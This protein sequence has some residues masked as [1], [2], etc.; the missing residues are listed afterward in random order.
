MIRSGAVI[1]GIVELANDLFGDEVTVI[2]GPS[3]SRPAASQKILCVGWDQNSPVHASTARDESTLD[4]RPTE[5][6]VVSC[7]IATMSGNADMKQSRD[8]AVDLLHRLEDALI[9]DRTGLN[10]ACDVAEIGPETGLWQH[11]T[12]QGASVGIPFAVMYEAYL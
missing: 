9:A 1:D 3:K 2:D 4:G 11:Q 8:D 5:A 12:Q 10:G 7:Y 6:G